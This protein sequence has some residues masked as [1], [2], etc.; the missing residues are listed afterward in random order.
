MLKILASVFI[1]ALSLAG[2]DCIIRFN[3]SVAS[4][5]I[6]PLTTTAF[7]NKSIACVNWQLNVFVSGVSASSVQLESASDLGGNTPGTFAAFAGTVLSG[8]NPTTTTTQ[9]TTTFTGMYPWLRV[10]PTSA[11]GSGNIVGV[12]YGFKAT[13]SSISPSFGTS[14]PGQYFGTFVPPNINAFTFRNQ[15]TGHNAVQFLDAI[16]ISNP[17]STAASAWDV[18]CVPISDIDTTAT[19]ITAA[20]QVPVSDSAAN[21]FEWGIGLANSSTTVIRYLYAVCGVGATPC[22]IE[23]SVRC[24]N[25]TTATCS[26]VAS[27]PFGNA[28][29][30][31]SMPFLWLRWKSD[32]AGNLTNLASIDGVH[33]VNLTTNTQVIVDTDAFDRACMMYMQSDNN[34]SAS[35]NFVSWQVTNP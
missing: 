10:N 35:V 4:N 33:F 28:H 14:G 31:F 17:I 6:T 8:S 18:L 11:T 30:T 15:N 34:F 32:G 3:F 12:A 5:V 20:I 26:A 27:P 9:S 19:T 1:F 13:S 24:T 29:M 23:F 25:F 22:S 21:N 2:Q 7:N 16:N